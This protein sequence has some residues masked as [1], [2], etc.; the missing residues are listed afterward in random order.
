MSLRWQVTKI[1]SEEG[2]EI[3][4][5]MVFN[6]TF[7]NISVIS[8]RLVL[9][10]KETADLPQ[11]TKSCIEYNSPRV[12]FELTTFVVIG[13]ECIGSC[14]WWP[15]SYKT[16]H[17]KFLHKIY[18]GSDNIFF[19]FDTYGS[20]KKQIW[21]IMTK[22]WFSE[23]R[24]SWRLMDKELCIPTILIGTGTFVIWSFVIAILYISHMCKST[25]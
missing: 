5:V 14:P 11:V 20:S 2:N 21:R 10:V 9:L 16:T 12:G 25:N 23:K 17:D 18:N 15:L 19:Q 3:F 8:W 7:N 24:S 13:T 6:A 22:I 1:S 4:W